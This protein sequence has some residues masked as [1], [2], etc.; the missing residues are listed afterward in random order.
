MKEWKSAFNQSQ[1]EASGLMSSCCCRSVDLVAKQAHQAGD[2]VSLD[3]G[4]K[5]LCQTL[6]QYGFVPDHSPQEP[7]CHTETFEDFGS[8][9]ECLEIH[10]AGLV[11]NLGTTHAVAT[12]LV[13]ALPALETYV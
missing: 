8:S 12:F 3:Y 4:D 6:L 2:A 9:W 5:S 1:G 7:A 11:C 10:A 13:C